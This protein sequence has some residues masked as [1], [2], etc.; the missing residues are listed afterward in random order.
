MSSDVKKALGKLRA[1]I[2]EICQCACDRDD[3]VCPVRKAKIVHLET[4]ERELE[5]RRCIQ[6]AT[7]GML[8]AKLEEVERIRRA[9]DFAMKHIGVILDNEELESV[10]RAIHRKIAVPVDMVGKVNVQVHP[11]GTMTQYPDPFEDES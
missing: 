6:D 3:D 2:T 8:D 7:N 10:I 5:A 9:L 1:F 11:D 4:V